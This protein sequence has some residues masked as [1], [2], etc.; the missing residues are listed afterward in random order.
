M[1]N[2]SRTGKKYC[3]NDLKRKLEAVHY[4]KSHT[5]SETARHFKVDAKMIRIW[6]SQEEKLRQACLE[7]RSGRYRLDGGGRKVKFGS[8]LHLTI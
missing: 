8:D 5:I 2:S 3:K 7:G 1:P 6:K 4:S